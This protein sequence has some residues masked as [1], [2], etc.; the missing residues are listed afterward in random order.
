MK[1]KECNPNEARYQCRRV[2]GLDFFLFVLDKFMMWSS[3]NDKAIF[4]VQNWR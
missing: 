3:G 2:A 4:N 1:N